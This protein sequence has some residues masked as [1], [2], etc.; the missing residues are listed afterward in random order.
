MPDL[1]EMSESLRAV[2]ALDSLSLSPG[3][4]DADD[5]DDE[6]LDDDDLDDDDDDEEF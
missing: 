1:F 3:D 2:G 5:L 6:D 4:A